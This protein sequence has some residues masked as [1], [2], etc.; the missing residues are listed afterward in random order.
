MTTTTPR[1]VIEFAEARLSTAQKLFADNPN[2][3]HWQ[4]ALRAM[5]IYQQVDYVQRRS[6]LLEIYALCAA[7]DKLDEGASVNEWDDAISGHCVGVS[8]KEAL[9]EFAVF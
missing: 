2:S 1:E 6:S 7:I 4:E 3:V 5:F 9:Q 8:M